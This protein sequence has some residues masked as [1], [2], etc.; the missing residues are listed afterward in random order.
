MSYTST[1]KTGIVN[2]AQ[3]RSCHTTCPSSGMAKPRARPKAGNSTQQSSNQEAGKH[4]IDLTR[5]ELPPRAEL[6]NG[7]SQMLGAPG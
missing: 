6:S 5:S 3:T 7:Y 1:I 2:A 4:S